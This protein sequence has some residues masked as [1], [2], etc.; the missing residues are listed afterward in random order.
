M[1]YLPRLIDSYLEDWK[2]SPNHKP[3][4]IRGARQVGKSW[5][6]RHLG[7]KFKSFLEINFEKQP[8]FKTIF[9][10]NLDVDR[11]LAQISILSN[12][13]IKD[14]ETLLFLDEIQECP[15]AIMALRFFKEDRP[16]LHVAAAGSLLE[17][18]LA[19]LP[20]FGVGRIHSMFM[21]PLTFDEFLKANDENSL[22]EARNMASSD[23]PLPQIIHDKLVEYFRLYVLI[24]GMPEIVS[25]WVQTHDY[26]Q[27][28]QLAN[29]LIVSYGD[30]FAKY[31][32]KVEPELLRNTLRS[33]A[34]Q[35]GKKFV[36]A[37][38]PGNYKTY[39]VK[40]AIELLTM[41]GLIIPVI[42]TDANGLPL[43]G[44]A[45]DGYDKMIMLDTALSLR[46]LD[47]SLD[48]M[49]EIRKQI[50]TSST[51]ELVNK[52]PMMEMIAGLEY[53]RYLTP[54][55][56]HELFYWKRSEKNA[57]SEVD[58]IISADRKIIPM[59]IKAET[60]GSMKSLWIF[61]REKHLERGIRSSLENFGQFE[62]VDKD[63]ENA[64]RNIVICPLYAMSQ[65]ER[66]LKS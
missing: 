19:E 62:Y 59:E 11:I 32:K 29:D 53:L 31:R 21:F 33:V 26:Y 48:K 49:G 22:L 63:E 1:S 20:T 27:C 66:L 61:M 9:Q 56:R 37:Y 58:Y 46:M 4:L 60:K 50:L 51:S 57:L 44:E 40:K 30:D 34:N 64:K 25:C 55:L 47:F 23:N 38:V 35:I 65:L 16:A 2:N 17:F 12:V 36:Y 41:A 8:E 18:A 24:G 39:E 43:G 42:R 13:S 7:E 10:Q 52:G 5:A 54:N 15:E 14:D 45:R 3:L 6:I 28:Q